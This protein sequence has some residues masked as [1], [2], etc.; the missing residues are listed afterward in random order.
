MDSGQLTIEKVT[1][2]LHQHAFP[3]SVEAALITIRECSIFTR[4]DL[5]M[6]ANRFIFCHSLSTS[7]PNQPVWIK[8][9]NNIQELHTLDM[10]RQF[11]ENQSDLTIS[12]RVFDIIF[13]DIISD[14][15]HPLFTLYYNL[16]L[17][18]LSLVL[19]FESKVT[20]T[21]ITRWF[22]TLSKTI[23]SLLTKIIEYI[24]REHI[25]L[26]ITK[27]VNNLCMISPLFT[28]C[29]INQTCILLD[30]ENL[31]LDTKIIQTLIELLT[32]GL[33]NST[34]LL[35]MTLQQEFIAESKEVFMKYRNSN[36]PWI[37]LTVAVTT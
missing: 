20:L 26:A 7:N 5:S 31:A 35:L 37:M 24:I 17:K 29:F 25:A 14:Q 8:T 4:K 22:L 23:D 19:S 32:Y 33:T 15:D 28:L 6:L 30:K 2:L 10:V 1:Q 34:N 3:A 9:L 21:I 13:F 16:L 27:S 36:P 11:L 18:F 12:A